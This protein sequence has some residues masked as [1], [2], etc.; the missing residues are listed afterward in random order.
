LTKLLEEL[1]VRKVINAWGT[2][3]VLG[4]TTMSAEVIEAMGEASQVYVDM[5]E[6]H[7]KAGDF[8]ARKL[9]VEAACI[10]SGAT[11]GL[12]LSTA[13]CITGGNREKILDLPKAAQGARNKVL[14]QTVHRNGFVNSLQLAG[15]EVQMVGGEKETTRE[16]FEKALADG[17][18]AAVMYFVFDPQ[19]GVLPLDQVV[20]IAH[21]RGIPVLVDAASELPPL[22]NLKNFSATGADLVVFSGG[23]ALGGPNDTGLIL[24]RRDLI[25]TCLR[26]EYYET[27]GGRSV[28][29]LGRSMKVS[30]EDILALVTAVI[31][32]LGRDHEEEMRQ[33]ELKV[34][35]MVSELSSK[36]KNLPAPQKVYPGYGHGPRP[37]IFPRCALDFGQST[38][39]LTAEM[40]SDGL[41][42]GNPP[43]YVYVKDNVLFLNPQCLQDQEEK[44]IVSRLVE[45][46]G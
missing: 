22:E 2:V 21:R 18:V 19:P 7:R 10:S 20:Q 34:D 24:G 36:A 37:L 1:G 17:T 9:G 14:V 33:W 11:A 46:S 39:G 5:K 27:V 38:S 3:T 42:S 23:K 16:E 45:L 41:K 15:A 32:Y 13:A 29:L 6:L 12:I 31:Q 40:L 8:I 26:L 25:D 28:A 43:I 35:Y 30:K 44:I 4:G